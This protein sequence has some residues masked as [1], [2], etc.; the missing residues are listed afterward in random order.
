MLTENLPKAK[1]M[2]ILTS[3]YKYKKLKNNFKMYV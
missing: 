1:A 2:E 3:F